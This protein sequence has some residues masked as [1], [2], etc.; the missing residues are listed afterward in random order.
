MRQR[1]EYKQVK[2][3]LD[4]AGLSISTVTSKQISDCIDKADVSKLGPYTL[5]SLKGCLLQDLKIKGI[6]ADKTFIIDA[7]KHK[8]PKIEMEEENNLEKPCFLIWP[9]GKP[10]IIEDEE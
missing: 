2:A 4:K 1:E 5:E 8:W 9:E 6:E 10:I 7:L 3:E